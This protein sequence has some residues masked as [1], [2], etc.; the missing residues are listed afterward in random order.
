MVLV[1]VRDQSAEDKMTE[2]EVKELLGF[3]TVPYVDPQV[4]EVN[5]FS[6]QGFASALDHVCRS[7]SSRQES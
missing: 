5:A 2:G 7:V 6:G 3:K 4:I 1:N